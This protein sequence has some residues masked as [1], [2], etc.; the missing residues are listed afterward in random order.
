MM[1]AKYGVRIIKSEKGNVS[2]FVTIEWRLSGGETIN[3][4]PFVV[5]VCLKLTFSVSIRMVYEA[6]QLRFGCQ[7]HYRGLHGH[8]VE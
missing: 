5:A 4:F 7:T 8:N 1:F 3:I 2:I 6:W